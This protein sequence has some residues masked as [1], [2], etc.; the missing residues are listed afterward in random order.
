[1]LFLRLALIERS[2]QVFERTSVR[3][4]RSKWRSDDFAGIS[5]QIDKVKIPELR[6]ESLLQWMQ[7]L[8]AGNNC[9]AKLPF[10]GMLHQP[11][12]PRVVDDVEADLGKS[13]ALALFGSQDVIV[14]LM[15]ELMR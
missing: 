1:S 13:I 15:L 14:S 3:C 9:A 12:L 11:F 5:S 2:W 10:Y 4:Y 6:P 8:V 7:G